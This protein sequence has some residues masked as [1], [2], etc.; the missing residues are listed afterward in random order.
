LEELD[1]AKVTNFIYCLSSN[2]SDT[3]ANALGVLSVISLNHIPS[4]FSLSV[5]CSIIDV[6]AGKHNIIMQFI[7]PSG[8]TLVNIDSVIPYERTDNMEILQKY[9]GIN[10]SSNWQN[11]VID[12][13]GQYR[14]V[15]KFDGIDCG[16]Y[17]ISVVDD[18]KGE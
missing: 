16:S 4:T 5:L 6:G 13:P 12:E 18:N 17:D 1:L 7:S 14:T 8:K 11:I 9:S 10:I 15:I 3:E 2:T